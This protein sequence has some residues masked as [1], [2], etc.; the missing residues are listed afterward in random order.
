MTSKKTYLD[1]IIPQ[2]PRLLSLMD[3][4]EGSRTYG[5]C[6]PNYWKYNLTDF[7]CARMQELVLTL[8]IEYI[9]PE[10]PFYYDKQ[11]LEWIRAGI[12]YWAK[13]QSKDG[14]F[15]EWYPN[16]HSYVATAMSAYAIAETICNAGGDLNPSWKAL[17]NAGFF[18]KKRRETRATN[19]EIAAATALSSIHKVLGN[20]IWSD[21][22]EDKIG[23]VLEQQHDEGWFNEYGGADTGYLSLS[24]DF[25]AKYYMEHRS[26]EVKNALTRAICFISNMLL[27]D[28]TAFPYGSRDTAYLIPSGFEIMAEE[29]PMAARIAE[30]IRKS[31]ELDTAPIWDD[32]Y[33]A[34]NGYTLLQAY[35]NAKDGLVM[36]PLP[37]EQEFVRTFEDY[38]IYSGKKTYCIVN[39]A[40]GGMVSAARKTGEK[41][42]E[43]R[44]MA[45]FHSVTKFITESNDHAQ[46]SEKEVT[47][48]GKMVKIPNTTLSP[49]KNMA[50]RAFQ[51]TLG[52]SQRIAQKVKEKAR[53]RV[54]TDKKEADIRYKRTIRITEDEDVQVL[55][56]NNLRLDMRDVQAHYKYVPSSR[57]YYKQND[58]RIRVRRG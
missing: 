7:P 4:S 33:L 12:S 48:D 40:R 47:V 16:E 55:T 44:P 56:T 49:N 19:Q 8:S 5:C 42:L 15:S 28:H 43:G 21:S 29:I 58:N 54:I 23:H 17:R 57:F 10:S 36:V 35:A 26:D 6:D 45:E 51:Q 30:F 39:H 31:Y 46:F 27:P 22:A 18:L 34:Y 50:L 3:R 25:L 24:I 2:I 11:M 37:Y 13:S 41:I 52:R 20:R 38:W 9:R 14:S 32:R 53:N 1:R